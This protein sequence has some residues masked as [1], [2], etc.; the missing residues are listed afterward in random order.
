MLQHRFNSVVAYKFLKPSNKISYNLLKLLLNEQK[1][2]FSLR[3]ES[4]ISWRDLFYK[5]YSDSEDKDWIGSFVKTTIRK[6]MGKVK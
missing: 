3:L 2:I 4:I 5:Q 6:S 1:I